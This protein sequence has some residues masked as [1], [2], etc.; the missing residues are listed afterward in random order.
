V[1]EE[2]RDQPIDDNSPISLDICNYL[3]ELAVGVL[4]KSQPALEI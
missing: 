2:A 3:E 4:R 1:E